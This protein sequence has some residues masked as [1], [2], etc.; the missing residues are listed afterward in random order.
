M[1]RPVVEVFADV[2]CPFTHVG[3]RHIIRRRAAARQPASAAARPAWPLELVNGE[4]LDPDVVALGTWRSYADRSSPTS[5]E[6]FD[7]DAYPA[8]H[9]PRSRSSWTLTSQ[10]T[11]SAS[12]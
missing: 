9:S 11:A 8:R 2:A 3:L 10:A 6:G 12:R 5:F 4:P 7:S 1:T